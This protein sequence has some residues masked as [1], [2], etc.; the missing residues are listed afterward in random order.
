MLVQIAC[1]QVYSDKFYTEPDLFD[2]DAFCVACLFAGLQ[3]QDI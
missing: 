3:V 2:F 1:S